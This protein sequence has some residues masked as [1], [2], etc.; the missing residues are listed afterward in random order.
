VS[1]RPGFFLSSAIAETKIVQ[2]VSHGGLDAAAV[3][4]LAQ[5]RL[6]VAQCTIGSSRDAL[7]AGHQPANS[8]IA[9]AAELRRETQ[10]I[11]MALRPYNMLPM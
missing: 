7:R 4:P 9:T 5:F 10:R 11:G 3:P 6:F 1:A 2:D 8:A